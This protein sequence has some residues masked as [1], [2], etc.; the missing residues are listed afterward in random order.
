M[1]TNIGDTTVNADNRPHRESSPSL[2]C[3]VE[4][5][6]PAMPTITDQGD[7]QA[8]QYFEVDLF[9]HFLLRVVRE[10]DLAEFDLPGADGECTAV[11][12]IY[13]GWFRVKGL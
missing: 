7:Y 13:Y 10:I 5:S 12:W 9:D 6:G 2:N 4:Q 8:R 3:Q 1:S 11:F